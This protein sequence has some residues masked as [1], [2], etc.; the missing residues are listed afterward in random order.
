MSMESVGF[1][2]G[3]NMTRAIAGGLLDNGFDPRSIAIA[4][5][6]SSQ[7]QVLLETL[8]GV[9][10][11]EDNAAVVARS[12]CIVLAVKP[13]VLPAVCSDLAPAVKTHQPLIISI[14]AG[15]RI[16]DIDT[17]LSG[18]NAIVRVMPNQPALI[19]RG[20][21]GIFGNA[22]TSADQISMAS[23]ILS[24]VGPVVTVASEADIDAVTAVSGSG[25][26]YF[27]LLID[28]IT[29]AGVKLGLDEDTANRLALETAVGATMLAQQSG[30]PM[31]ALIARVRSPGGTTA[32]ALD[33][34]E[35]RG[36]RDIFTAALTAA[37]DRATELADAAHKSARD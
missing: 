37:R 2:G 33:E 6:L 23:K 9:F 21:S 1:I 14:A 17:W 27:Y 31:E 32:A 10:I 11:S 20:V 15:P 19:G 35:A 3:G 4:E 30:D 16:D 28:M 36:I 34:L 24:A 5:R 7:R 13:Q 29:K 12:Q 25:P 18:G 22:R 26:A 8:P